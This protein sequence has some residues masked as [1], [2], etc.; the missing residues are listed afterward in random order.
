MSQA[1]LVD[2][3]VKQNHALPYIW[4]LESRFG[5]IF[6]LPVGGKR[7]TLGYWCWL[8]SHAL[9]QDIHLAFHP[10]PLTIVA[11]IKVAASE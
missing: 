6:S 2:I 3:M 5:H 7:P 8:S 4:S 10:S 1:A 11:T 9:V